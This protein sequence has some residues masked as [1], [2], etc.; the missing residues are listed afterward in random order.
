VV[1]SQAPRFSFQ[2]RLATKNTPADAALHGQ[3][4]DAL[5]IGDTLELREAELVI[6]RGRSAVQRFAQPPHLT[7]RLIDF[8]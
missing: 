2:L 1:E 6:S 5:L 4:I 7:W 8:V 3:I